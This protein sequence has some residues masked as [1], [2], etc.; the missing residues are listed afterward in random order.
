MPLHDGVNYLWTDAVLDGRDPPPYVERLPPDLPE[1]FPPWARGRE[2]L[3]LFLERLTGE[4]LE[5]L[6]EALR[7]T[8]AE[9]ALPCPRLFVSH[10]R[11]DVPQALRIAY[12]AQQHGF[13]YWVDVLDPGLQALPKWRSSLTPAQFAVLTAG[14]IEVGLANST[15]VCAAWT[16]RTPGS[17]WVPYEY[18]R[19]A[20]SRTRAN[21]AGAWVEQVVPLPSLPEYM[22]LGPLQRTDADV[23]AWLAGEHARYGPGCPVPS[24]PPWGYAVPQPLP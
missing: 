24:L 15:H 18:G 14:I 21:A 10:R 20:D 3:G 2:A 11:L 4:S 17:A 23:Q 9:P 7:V 22:H 5:E 13:H 6:R 19:V 1:R 16:R 12:L 8:P